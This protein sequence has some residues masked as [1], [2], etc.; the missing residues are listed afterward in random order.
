M[1]HDLT[2][3]VHWQGR[4]WAV[5]GYGI[6]A[7][8]GMYHVP[9]AEIPDAEAERPDWLADLWNRYGTDRD[10]LA[11]ALRVARSKLR[12]AKPSLARPAA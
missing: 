1:G 4:Q 2:D 11:A 7:L 8:D 12:E 5:T 3:P 6:E 10:D 9:F